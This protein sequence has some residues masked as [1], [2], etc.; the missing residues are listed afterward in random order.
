[1][2]IIRKNSAKSKFMKFAF[3][4][5]LLGIVFIS[6]EG[7]AISSRIG[8]VVECRH[9]NN[10]GNGLYIKREY[11]YE[12]YSTYGTRTECRFRAYFTAEDTKGSQSVI[13]SLRENSAFP[14]NAEK[15]TDVGVVDLDGVNFGGPQFIKSNYS[16]FSFRPI[17]NNGHFELRV[18]ASPANNPYKELNFNYVYNCSYIP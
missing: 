13:Q 14:P 1:M 15:F 9:E 7:G 6:S 11:C 8:N 12:A 16:S 5:A 18:T 4:L 17:D 3:S 2:K 10:N